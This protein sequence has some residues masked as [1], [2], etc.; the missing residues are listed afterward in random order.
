MVLVS[1]KLDEVLRATDDI[2][3]MRQ[4]AVVERIPTTEADAPTLARAMVGRE[5]SLRSE[6]AA[7]GVV[8]L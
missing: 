5:V 2:T 8:G 3:I 6:R 4:G 7:F 1:H